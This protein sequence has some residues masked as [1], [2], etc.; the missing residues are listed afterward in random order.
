MLML[1]PKR[2]RPRSLPCQ[3]LPI[4]AGQSGNG[5]YGPDN[6]PKHKDTM[7]NRRN[8]GSG[9]T[10]RVR[11]EE[12]A[13]RDMVSPATSRIAPSA[14]KPAANRSVSAGGVEAAKAASI[15]EARRIEWREAYNLRIATGE[16]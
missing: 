10:F 8:G 13:G 15:D 9:T 6:G 4:V 12:L 2:M 3:R 1:D 11:A 14:Y 5:H 16:E 7:S